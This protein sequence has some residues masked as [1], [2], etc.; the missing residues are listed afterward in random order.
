MAGAPPLDPMLDRVELG[1]LEKLAAKLSSRA[2]SGHA[3]DLLSRRRGAGTDFADRRAY[4]PGDDP[5]RIDWAAYGRT[6]APHVKLYHGEEELAVYVVLDASASVGFGAPRKIDVAR[7]FA[8]AVAYV[9]LCRGFRVEVLA[10]S[11]ALL[12]CGTLGR[13]DDVARLASELRKIEPRGKLDLRRHLAALSTRSPGLLVVVSDFLGVSDFAGGLERL[14]SR[15]HDVG[16]VQLL[17]EEELDPGLTGDL[18]LV[19]AETGE[20]IAVSADASFA[21]DYAEG[22]ARLGGSLAAIARKS[23]G[24]Y[25]RTDVREGTIALVDRFLSRKRA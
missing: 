25:V 10:A 9:A 3:G 20:E 6:G 1:R 22:L 17:A 5:R 2:R 18:T 24:A 7:R 19:D 4:E 11:E 12:S 15:G 8:L 23:G 13:R 16:V 14:A 21:A